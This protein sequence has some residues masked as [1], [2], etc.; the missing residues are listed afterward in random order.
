[1]SRRP[2]RVRTR[3]WCSRSD[4]RTES[5]ISELIW[6]PNGVYPSWL[7]AQE[8]APSG[9]FS[10][11]STGSP[12]LFDLLY[13]LAILVSVLYLVGWHTLFGSPWMDGS[14]TS[15]ILPVDRFSLPILSPWIFQHDLVSRALTYWT[16]L[17]ELTSPILLWIPATR[18]LVAVQSALFH[19]GIAV[20]MG[21]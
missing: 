10:L 2:G 3:R 18:W 15:I 7:L 14:A 5:R 1:S 16:V 11:F 17:F 6:G 4:R 20:L 19:G 13:H 9:A 21:L 12:L 8:L